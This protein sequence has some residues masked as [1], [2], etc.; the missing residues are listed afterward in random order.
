[1]PSF[2]S[3]EFAIECDLRVDTN[4]SDDPK[5]RRGAHSLVPITLSPRI[6]PQQRWRSEDRSFCTGSRPVPHSII[7][8]AQKNFAGTSYGPPLSSVEYWS[9]WI[10]KRGFSRAIRMLQFKH[11]KQGGFCIW[12]ESFLRWA[13]GTGARIRA[14]YWEI[15]GSRG[16]CVLGSPLLEH[17]EESH[18]NAT[19]GQETVEA[20]SVLE[21][22][23]FRDS[24]CFR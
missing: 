10:W 13:R 2:L 24:P 1:M 14:F 12:R 17:A 21:I 7:I 16:A 5:A 3:Q 9:R 19:S 20:R 6:P 8:K 15:K 18:L 11:I 4:C 22:S 23:R